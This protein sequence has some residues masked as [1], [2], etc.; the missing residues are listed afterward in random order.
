MKKIIIALVAL[1]AVPAFGTVTITLSAGPG[2]N[3]VTVGFTSDEPNLVRA[4]ALDIVLDDPCATIAEVNCVSADYG[5]YPGSIQINDQGEVTDDGTCVGNPA[6]GPAGGTQPG[7]DSNGVTIEMG[8]LYAEG[9]TPP[10]NSGNPALVIITLGGCDSGDDDVTVSVAENDVRGGVVM[11]NPDEVV[12]VDTSAE[13][14]AGASL[15]ACEAPC[16][17]GDISGPVGVPDGIVSTSDMSALLI[18][19]SN[20]GPPYSITPVPAGMECM[21]VSGPVGVPDGAISTSDMSALLIHLNN[22]GPPYQAGCMTVG[23]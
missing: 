9:E 17:Y 6:Q 2:P 14:V 5:I 3:D 10:D 11:E 1:M 4:F 19:L 22:A 23:P 12:T 15:V 8:S 16:C 7:L 21:D 18:A 13:L 20:A